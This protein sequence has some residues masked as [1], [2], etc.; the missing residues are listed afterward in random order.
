MRG[1]AVDYEE[2][3]YLWT[4]E[5]ARLLRS[6][7]FSAIDA[8]NIAEE[9]ESMG[10]S[11]RRELKSRLIVLLTHLLK[12]RYQPEARSRSWS[13][14]IREQRQQIELVLEDSPS[15]RSAAE[16]MLNQVYWIARENAGEETGITKATFPDAC[17]FRPDE[18]LSRGFLPEP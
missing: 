11:D 14:T 16:Q 1:N 2:D 10:R 6:G 9:I 18:V 4:E 13:D 12:W 17:P 15:L 8:A 7:E 5:Q 3:F